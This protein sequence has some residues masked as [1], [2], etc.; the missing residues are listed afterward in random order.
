MSDEIIDCPM[1]GDTA[2]KHMIEDQMKLI[3]DM[4]R[5]DERERIIAIGEKEKA[6][7]KRYGDSPTGKVID[8]AIDVIDDY[9]EAIKNQNEA[10]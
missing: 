9:I 5:A 2:E 8:I 1:C 10:E 7:L 4:V 3:E 6:A